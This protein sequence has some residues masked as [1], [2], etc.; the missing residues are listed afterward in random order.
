MVN[1]QKEVLK[2]DIEHPTA[3][4]VEAWVWWHSTRNIGLTGYT[5]P[6]RR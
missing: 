1:L 4:S 5:V 3:H 6:I 2:I